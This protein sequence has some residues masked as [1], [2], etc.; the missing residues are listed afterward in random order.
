MAGKMGRDR[1]T[2]K[3]NTD[4]WMQ[5]SRGRAECLE[6]SMSERDVVYK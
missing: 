2:M 1:V 6:I 3:S 4:A 5:A